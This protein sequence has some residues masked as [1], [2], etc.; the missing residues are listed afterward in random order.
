MWL[1][2]KLV[3]SKTKFSELELIE[4]VFWVN[5]EKGRA[6]KSNSIGQKCFIK[7]FVLIKAINDVT[8]PN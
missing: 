1:I 5:Y 8:S 7:T 3:I 4:S 6:L 2:G